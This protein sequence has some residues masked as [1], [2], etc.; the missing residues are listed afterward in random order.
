VKQLTL[1]KMLKNIKK[2]VEKLIKEPVGLG[3]KAPVSKS[4]TLS[5]NHSTTKSKANTNNYEMK[6]H[7]I[8]D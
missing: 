7:S 1:I 5:S 2:K 8:K 6:T 4:E 3:M